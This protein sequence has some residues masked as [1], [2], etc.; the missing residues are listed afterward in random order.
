M[1]EAARTIIES[2]RER[3]TPDEALATR[4]STVAARLEA[5]ARAAVT[6]LPVEA[7]ILR[8][9][10]TA[11]NTWTPE[12]RDIDIF[13]RF[14]PSLSR[15]DLERYGLAVGSKVLPDGRE[16]YAEH[17]YIT[18]TVEGFDVDLVPCYAVPSATEAKS[19]VDRT[20]F[21][22][23]YVAGALTPQLAAD[24]RV[25]KQF[26]RAAGIYGSNLKTRGFSG[27]LT[28]LLILEYNGVLG[29][30]SA[31]ADWH[32]PIVLDPADH[33]EVAFDDPLVVYDPTDPARNVAAV[34][35]STN[36]ARLQHYARRFLADPRPDRF[37]PVSVTPIDPDDLR[38]VIADRG[39]TVLALRFEVEDIVDD[40]LYPQLDRSRD[41]LVRALERE[42]FTVVRSDRF[43]TGGPALAD[44]VLLFELESRIVPAIQRHEG[45]P[46]G[47]RN[48]AESFYT[49][50][51]DESVYGPFIDGNRYVVERYRDHTDAVDYISTDGITDAALGATVGRVLT[52]NRTVLVDEELLTL[53]EKPAFG[54][55][56]TRYFDPRP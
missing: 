9:G 36:L 50:Y 44:A 23:D 30:L 35:A 2:V 46:V 53:L 34:L 39:T 14:P 4:L 52:T 24:V 40:Q 7:D 22:N 38:E 20:P 37:E 33:G 54:R 45:P 16:E 11:R 51:A 49:K 13:V 56:L 32:P 1:N 12:D 28:E 42:G 27:Y 8:V 41:G 10:S 26:L 31:A 18:G 15:D 48:H 3:V 17:P 6:E 55:A 19:A 5:E 43:A 25:F 47:V 29:V 21:H